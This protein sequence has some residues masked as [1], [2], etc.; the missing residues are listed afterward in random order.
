[1]APG[2]YLPNFEA[3]LLSANSS[4]SSLQN[5]LDP[6][7]G[8]I[9]GLNCKVLGEDFQR[10]INSVCGDFYSGL[11]GNRLALGISCFGLLFGSC[12]MVCSGSRHCR[13]ST[14]KAKVADLNTT[15]NSKARM[16]EEVTL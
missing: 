2:G 1:M 5:L 8:L 14:K 4:L 11:W 6:K 9:G 16:R 7:Y 12:C 13:E 3:A 10:I 15:N